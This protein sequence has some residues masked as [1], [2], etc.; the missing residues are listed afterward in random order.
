[1]NRAYFHIRKIHTI[2][3]GFRTSSAWITDNITITLYL[4]T[5]NKYLKMITHRHI[6]VFKEVSIQGDFIFESADSLEKLQLEIRGL[7]AELYHHIIYVCVLGNILPHHTKHWLNEIVKFCRPVFY[8]DLKKNCASIDR[9]ELVR[10][11]MMSHY[12]GA[13]FEDYD[14]DQFEYALQCEINS[15]ERM[16]KN[17][18]L[19]TSWLSI[20]KEL[21]IIEETKKHLDG[22]PEMCYKTIHSFYEEFCKAATAR[23][24]DMLYSAIE[25]IHPIVC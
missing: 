11:H 9:G 25:K 16:L 4:C 2:L 24:I 18:K 12:M 5:K 21:A 13:D 20:K 8:T 19:K 15:G 1:M 22:I 14:K 23:N 17:E 3:H 7:G 10:E 6:K